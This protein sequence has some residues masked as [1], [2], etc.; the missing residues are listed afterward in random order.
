ME[1]IKRAEDQYLEALSTIYHKGKD[2]PNERTGIDCRTFINIDLTYDAS[3]NK[4]PLVTTRKAPTKLP[5]AELLGYIRGYT[6]AE[7]FRKL[8]S[9]SW[10]MNANE[11]P[12]WLANP[13]RKGKDD[14][15]LV[16]GAVARNWPIF[17]RGL[18]DGKL[19]VSHSLDLFEKVYNNLKAGKDDRGEVISYWN[20]GFFSLGCLRPCL[21]SYQ[22]SLLGDDL[23]LNATQ[24]SSDFPIG[25]V[26]NMVQVYTFLRLMA[27]ITNK[28]PK[29]AFHK[30]VNAHIY[31]NQLEGVKEQL[32]RTPLEEPTL[33]INPDIKTLEDVMTWV[34]VDDIRI[35][36][37][38]YHPPINFPFA[39]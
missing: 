34:T 28:N 39:I 3:T 38:E 27:Q 11:T 8:G 31:G 14:M 10:D 22:F 29:L 36:Y 20:P 33:E 7:D 21:H 12:A 16:Y 30:N 24:R 32:T 2:L 23:Y 9:K 35:D 5:I 6:S 25:T 15:G 18:E 13:N 17:E 4:V 1:T 37:S 19:V 26:A